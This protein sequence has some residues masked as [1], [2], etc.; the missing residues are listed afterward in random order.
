MQFYFLSFLFFVLFCLLFFFV[1]VFNCHTCLSKCLSQPEADKMIFLSHY[2]QP[3]HSKR[4][5][6]AHLW[7]LEDGK[8][9]EGKNLVAKYVWFFFVVVVLYIYILWNIVFSEFEIIWFI[10]MFVLAYFLLL[11]K[12]NN[13]CN[14]HVWMYIYINTYLCND[15]FSIT[16]INSSGP[17]Y[18]CCWQ[19][20][21]ASEKTSSIGSEVLFFILSLFFFFFGFFVCVSFNSQC[22]NNVKGIFRR[23]EKRGWK[24]KHN[25]KVLK[26]Q[27]W[28]SYLYFR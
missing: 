20:H 10:E 23:K 19:S 9:L 13:L 26:W 17:I 5:V 18:G 25:N 3:N 28:K 7:D 24:A 12:L 22:E 6:L 2:C 8:S 15:Y 1:F 14:I 16:C 21:R 4:L 11:L 27:K